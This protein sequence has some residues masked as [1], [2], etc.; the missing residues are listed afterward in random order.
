MVPKTTM[1]QLVCVPD[2]LYDCRANSSMGRRYINPIL[3][4]LSPVTIL[5]GLFTIAIFGFYVGL[6]VTSPIFLQTPVA[7]GGYGFTPLQNAACVSI[8][9]LLGQPTC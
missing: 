4:G 9:L 2:Q 5:A 8:F 7:E 6:G 1:K 3:I